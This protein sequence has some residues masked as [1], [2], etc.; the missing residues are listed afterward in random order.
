MVLGLTGRYCAG[1]DT[2]ARAL[3][4]RGYRVIDADALAHDALA[5]QAEKVFAAFG[6]GVQAPGGG[7]DR[8]A[9]GRIVFGDDAARE[10]LE[11][12]I[13]PPVVQKIKQMLAA[14]GDAVINAPLLHKAGLHALCNAVLFV[15][16]PA[17]IRLIRAMRR[18]SL[19]LR[20]AIARLSSQR[21]VR[22]QSN[23]PAVDTYNVP[24]W[25]SARALE[26]RIARLDRRLRG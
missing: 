3:A 23:G 15:R 6:Q 8:R 5:E 21:D 1:K 14:P 7:V 18:D 24:N 20:D 26:R 2:A 12:I 19:S 10:R 16:A 13:H 25:G 9:L 22:P 4:A 11:A 17:L